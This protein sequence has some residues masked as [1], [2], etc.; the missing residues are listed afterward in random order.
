ML[1]KDLHQL[2]LTR[3]QKHDASLELRSDEMITD[4]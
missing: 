4:G 3:I 1:Y 2:R